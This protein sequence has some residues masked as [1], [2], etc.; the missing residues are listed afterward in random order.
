MAAVVLVVG[1]IAGVAVP[2]Y[3]EARSTAAREAAFDNVRKID[4][5]RR[6]TATNS[7]APLHATKTNHLSAPQYPSRKY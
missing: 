3:I 7:A 4:V 2:R 5:A 6:L 1:L